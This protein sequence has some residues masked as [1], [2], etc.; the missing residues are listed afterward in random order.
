MSKDLI[1]TLVHGTFAHN[2]R[3]KW[4][5]VDSSLVS[6]LKRSLGEEVRFRRFEWDGKNTHSSRQ[7]AG[8]ALA[9]QLKEQA[10]QDPPATQVVIA[11][12][13]G[14][15]I[16]AYALSQSD[17]PHL[18]AVTLGT[19]FIRVHPRQLST[20]FSELLLKLFGFLLI[21]AIFLLFYLDGFNFFDSHSIPPGEK[22]AV[23]S[24]LLS[25][26]T[27]ATS[28][29]LFVGYFPAK[30]AAVVQALDRR[31]Q[32]IKY[33]LEASFAASQNLMIISVAGDEAAAGLGLLDYL[34]NIPAIIF[35]HLLQL[36]RNTFKALASTWVVCL[37][38]TP[39]FP[40]VKLAL[41][42]MMFFPP[43]MLILLVVPLFCLSLI[44]F[45]GYWDDRAL[46]YAYVRIKTNRDPFIRWTR[47]E[48][49]LSLD[50]RD[51]QRI[52]AIRYPRA[53]WFPLLSGG[54]LHHSSIYERRDI[55]ED[56][57]NWIIDGKKPQGALSFF[58]PS[59]FYDLNKNPK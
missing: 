37:F 34:G 59:K 46:D 4:M 28:V 49:D 55:L 52:V 11:H 16:L 42:L 23:L 19:P 1:V 48:I 53:R 26:I 32:V 13:H 33:Q 45:F 25:L 17:L 43:A 22:K 38:L 2:G 51:G 14:G 29:L 57:V 7:A 39:V 8:K 50:G 21:G 41:I 30:Y 47:K 5:S 18:L 10:C 40:F 56:I 36:S 15:N 20:I 9:M 54:A 12:S 35:D 58:P 44:R 3:A 27:I 31:E 6:V 24:F